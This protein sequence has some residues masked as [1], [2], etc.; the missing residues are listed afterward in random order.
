MNINIKEHQTEAPSKD[1]KESFKS[2]KNPAILSRIMQP[3]NDKVLVDI[4]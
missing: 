1:Q 2:W 3:I 4:I